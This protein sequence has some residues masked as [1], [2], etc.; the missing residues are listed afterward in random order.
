ME[1]LKER[2]DSNI[3]EYQKIWYELPSALNNNLPCYD[4]NAKVKNEKYIESFINTI[5]KEFLNYP[6]ISEEKSGWGQNIYKL[7]K[8]FGNN[9]EF[10]NKKAISFLFSK[11]IKSITKEF[12]KRAKDFDD[13]MTLQEI[14][15]AMR[16]VWIMNIS[17]VLLNVEVKFTNAIFAYSMLYPY[18]DNILDDKTLSPEYKKRINHTLKC[19]IQGKKAELKSDYEKRLYELIEIINNDFD[20]GNHK[21]LFQSILAIQEAQEFSVTQ[22][23][24]AFSP[25]EKDLLNISFIKGGTSVLAD[26]YLVKGE[27]TDQ[28]IKFMLGYGI[29][30]QLCDD[31]QDVQEDLKNNSV[32]I[33]SL[34]SKHWYL[35]NI[36]NK[37]INFVY[38]VIGIEL[39]DFH[40]ELKEDMDK[41]LKENCLLFTFFSMSNSKKYF[42]QNYINTIENY[43]PFSFSFLKS[44]QDSFRKKYSKIRK[45]YGEE[46]FNEMISYI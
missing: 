40:Y 24:K 7:V 8:D 38:H 36:T 17:Q 32:T 45:K 18:T 14:G 5:Y 9:S 21:N 23:N 28:E 2:I 16:N 31:L 19:I 1:A 39:K 43:M 34:T 13:K 37:L 46:T 35:D 33:F 30:L 3:N 6:D 26:G 25:F 12:F 4:L 10:T 20:R 11:D 41:F 42:S 22:Q 27:L 15:Q 44:I 29:M